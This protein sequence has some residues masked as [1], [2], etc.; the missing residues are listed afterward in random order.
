MPLWVCKSLFVFN[1]G[2]EIKPECEVIPV[3]VKAAVIL[4]STDLQGKA[5]L[6]CMT[7]HNGESGCITCEEPGH[8]VKQ[9]K[10]HT[11]CCP[12][13][14]LPEAAPKR[15]HESFLRNGLSAHRENKKVG[16]F[17]KWNVTCICT[18]LLLILDELNLKVQYIKNIFYILFWCTMYI[19]MYVW[20]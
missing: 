8:I 5:Y 3:T 15:T 10:G 7:Q 12:Y 16:F 6:T 20:Y 11:R 18:L 9:G 17:W 1:T 14:N 19:Y 2:L 13:R 4:G